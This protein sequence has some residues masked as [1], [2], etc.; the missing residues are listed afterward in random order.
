MFDKKRGIY[1]EYPEHIKWIFGYA[2]PLFESW[3]YKVKVVTSE[4]DYQYWFY[5]IIK[6][7][8]VPERI[9]KYAGFV[10]GGMCCMNRE[11]TRPIEKFVKSLGCKINEYIGIAIDEPE[12]LMRM[13]EK[14]GKISLLEIMGYKEADCA[15]KCKEYGLLSPSYKIFERGGCWFCPNQKIEGFA[16][17]KRTYPELWREL[18]LMAETDNKVS[19]NFRYSQSFWEVNA[20]VERY[21]KGGTNE[22]TTNQDN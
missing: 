20:E 19:E 16:Y 14:P 5:H 9:G 22:N 21:L 8:A 4:K 2:I 3:G 17:L 11:K 12:R 15:L 13:H 1:A 6:E 7:S 10:L 18:E